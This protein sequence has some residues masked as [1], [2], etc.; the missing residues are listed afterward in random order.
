MENSKKKNDLKWI[1]IVIV[2]LAV[3][4]AWLLYKEGVIPGLGSKSDRTSVLFITLD[5]IRAD[6]LGCMGHD[7]DVTPNINKLAASGALFKQCTTSAPISLSA[8]TSLI[9][10][11]DPYIHGVRLGGAFPTPLG[12]GHMTLAEVLSDQGY[13]TAA[14]VTRPDLYKAFSLDQGFWPNDFVDS[15]YQNMGQPGGQA[16][17]MGQPGGQAPGMGRPGGQAPGMG[18]PGGQ[19]PGM[20]R[21][22]GTGPGAGQPPS[23]PAAMPLDAKKLS[24]S[25]ITWLRANGDEPFFFW[26]HIADGSAPH[27]PLEPFASKYKD[28]YT[29]ELAYVDEQ[30]GRILDE[31]EQLGLS[32][33][34]LVVLAS[35]FG[36]GLGDHY[37][38]VHGW[39]L[40]D[41]T[42]RVPLVVSLPGKIAPNTTIDAQVRLIDTAPTILDLL[43][44][45]PKQDAQGISLVPLLDGTADDLGIAAYSET[46]IPLFELQFYPPRALRKAGWKY[47]HAPTPELYDLTADPGE[48]T[49]V[50]EKNPDLVTSMREELFTLLTGAPTLPEAGGVNSAMSEDPTGATSEAALLQFEA[51]DPKDH[52]TEVAYYSAG[53]LLLSAGQLDAAT[54]AFFEVVKINSSLPKPLQALTSIMVQLDRAD[55]MITFLRDFVKAKPD[56]TDVRNSLAGLLQD[57]GE[58]KEAIEHLVIVEKE[59]AADV[60]PMAQEAMK[61]LNLQLADL[62]YAD[63]QFEEAKT[64]I[65]SAVAQDPGDSTLRPKLICVL[66]DAGDLDEVVAESRSR[67]PEKTKDGKPIM[68][69]MIHQMVGK[70]LVQQGHVPQAIVHMKKAIELKPEMALYYADLGILLGQRGEV[71]ESAVYLS[72][73][74]ELK[75]EV[76]QWGQNLA[77]A[78]KLAGEYEQAIGVLRKILETHKNH[79]SGMSLLSLILATC[80]HDELRSGQ[81]AL[82]LALKACQATQNQNPLALQARAA[83]LAETG[84][85]K[86]AE[87]VGTQAANL[88]RGA[89]QEKLAM[90]LLIVT[91]RFYK[92][93]KP[94]REKD[95]KAPKD[96][97][98]EGAGSEAEG[99]GSEAEDAGSEAEGAGSEAEGAGSE[100]ENAGEGSGK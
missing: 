71:A 48:K 22:G 51:A 36:E 50:A 11:I 53:Q 24:D 54:H 52:A 83:A 99:A 56:R 70:S 98:A 49:N 90:S 95:P 32:E 8:V 96:P 73:A 81:E 72:K 26:V 69:H 65:R 97:K 67:L 76:A 19:G 91:N 100:A 58:V 37:E 55:D 82:T 18:R 42:T 38:D 60:D 10:G 12:E 20:A 45:E 86:E 85:F 75:P 44:M 33:N 28:P 64:R 13:P 16:P 46:L 27:I 14:R 57:K 78:Y 89:G 9:T 35:G 21:P 5:G 79:A 1:V 34:T 92:Q 77:Y 84:D 23:M 40:Y 59:L 41:E 80:P 3:V 62:F 93:G 2:I 61:R 15:Q 63:G 66:T 29:A 47:I 88:A 7:P 74:W 94:Y 4:A 87:K 6:R 17:G 30:V 39:S 68:D 43:G 31:V 25:A